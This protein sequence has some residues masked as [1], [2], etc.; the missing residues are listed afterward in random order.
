[1]FVQKVCFSKV[2]ISPSLFTKWC[3]ET[4]IPTFNI[5]LRIN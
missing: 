1:M 4:W 5:V 3:S 2:T